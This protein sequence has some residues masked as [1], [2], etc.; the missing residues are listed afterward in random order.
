M[1]DKA[2]QQGAGTTLS[3]QQQQGETP[4][5]TPKAPVKKTKPPFGD[6]AGL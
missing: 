2:N 6:L 5:V 4:E 3:Q 1:S